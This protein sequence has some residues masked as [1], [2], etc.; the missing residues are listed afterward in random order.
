MG[1]KN[2]KNLIFGEDEKAVFE[3]ITGCQKME[4]CRRDDEKAVFEETDGRMQELKP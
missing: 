1:C 4:N 3:Q 2:L